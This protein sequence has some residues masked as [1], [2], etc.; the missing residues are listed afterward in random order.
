MKILS[1]STLHIRRYVK[2]IPHVL[3]LYV[4]SVHMY[5]CTYTGCQGDAVGKGLDCQLCC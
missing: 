1:L 5:M 4:C 3:I 2:V